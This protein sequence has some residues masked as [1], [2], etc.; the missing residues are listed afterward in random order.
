MS[1][2]YTRTIAASAITLVAI[3]ISACCTPP[4]PAPNSAA[5]AQAPISHFK[6]YGFSPS[7]Q[8]EIN[9]DT[10]SYQVPDTA[11]THNTL[12]TIKISRL[13]YAKGV[14]YDGN[15]AGV[16]ITLDIRTG[17]C[18]NTTKNG[19]SHEF[20]ATL[21]HGDTIYKG[22]ADALPEKP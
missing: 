8:A 9:G 18:R 3:S 13:A 7:W 16:K 12:R 5:T 10:L 2:L 15:D 21:Y 6:A 22:C 14:N 1:I 4:Q 20:I 11:N 19:K 17:T